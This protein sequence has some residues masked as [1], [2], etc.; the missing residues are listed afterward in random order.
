MKNLYVGMHI[1][2]VILYILPVVVLLIS[3]LPGLPLAGITLSVVLILATLPIGKRLSF[4]LLAIP[5][6][7]LVISGLFYLYGLYIYR[8]RDETDPDF[9]IAAFFIFATIILGYSIITGLGSML[10]LLKHFLER[11][12]EQADIAILK[13]AHDGR[14]G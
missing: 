10:I 12:E 4:L 14:H 7:C 9:G 5:G 2:A 6:G 11:R 8:P 13:G 3:G 1:L